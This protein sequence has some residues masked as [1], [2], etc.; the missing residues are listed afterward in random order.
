MGEGGCGIF[1]LAC[2]DRSGCAE[3]PSMMR[4]TVGGVMRG[5]VSPSLAAIIH[6]AQAPAAASSRHPQGPGSSSIHQA[7][8]SVA[9]TC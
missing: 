1:D 2:W 7:Q 4:G 3:L 9:V 6:K 8:A 5:F